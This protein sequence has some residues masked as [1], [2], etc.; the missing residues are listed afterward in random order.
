[1]KA[2]VK[3]VC[4]PAVRGTAA[5]LILLL[6]SLM[7]IGCQ[8]G[9]GEQ[10]ASTPLPTAASLPPPTPTLEERRVQT[11]PEIGNNTKVIDGYLHVWY[12]PCPQQP[13][14]PTEWVAPIVLTDLNSGS[15]V[16]LNR[17]GTVKDS[18]QPNYKT[19][20]GQAALEVAL[21]DSSEMGQVVARPECPEQVYEPSLWQ[22]DGWPDAYAEDIGEPPIPKVAISGNPATSY[23]ETISPGWRGSYCCPMSGGR[24]ECENVDSWEG[25]AEAE[26]Y[27]FTAGIRKYFTVLSDESN[28]G[29]IRR[30]QVFTIQEKKSLL[31]LGRMVIKAGEEVYSI[32][33]PKGESLEM[34]RAPDIPEGVYLL[35]TTYE[36]P[37][38]EVEYGF[39]VELFE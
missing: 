21:K 22:Q 33:A 25:F 37:F 23:G 6:L 39:K 38:G 24:L 1:M 8:L 26:T 7:M 27:L 14:L 36:S 5:C 35:K 31:K 28:P 2:I 29:R 18:P 17:D 10:P 19:E 16:Y 9:P 34:I 11:G 13:Q 12:V 3:T 32:E 20:E 30:I 15:N 4:R